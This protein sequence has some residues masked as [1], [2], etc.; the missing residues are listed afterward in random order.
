MYNARRGIQKYRNGETV[1]VQRDQLVIVDIEATCW[2][3]A[4]PAGQHS[5]I[6]E[7]GVCLLDLNTCHPAHKRSILVRPERSLVSPFCTSLTT[8]T[9]EQVEDGFS[10]A[11]ACAV[12]ELEYDTPSRAWASWGH[13]D[14]RIFA[15]QCRE[16]RVPYPFSK[17]HINLKRVHADARGQRLG[18]A[19]ALE[20]VGLEMQGTHHRGHDDAWNSARLLGHLIQEHGRDLLARYW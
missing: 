12:L 19:R 1:P 18:L 4:P 17:H 5:E 8:L 13:Y 16:R 15:Q 3:T 6:I 9:P 11:D 10:F 20:A 7:I 14:F 2:D